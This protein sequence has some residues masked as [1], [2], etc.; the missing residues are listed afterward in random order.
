MSVARWAGLAGIKA[1]LHQER[2]IVAFA[3]PRGAEEE[4]GKE[5]SRLI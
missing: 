1:K 4:V 3:Q 5:R 2:P